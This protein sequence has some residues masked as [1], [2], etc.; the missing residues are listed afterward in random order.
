MGVNDIIALARLF[1]PIGLFVGYLIWSQTY[2]DKA[3]EKREE[4]DRV[5]ARERIE[6]DKAITAAM[7]LLATKIDGLRR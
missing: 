2:R 5:L 4:A 6:T 1:G 7:T 3:T